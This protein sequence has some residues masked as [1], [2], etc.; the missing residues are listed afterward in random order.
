[1]G[2][3]RGRSIIVA[4]PGRQARIEGCVVARHRPRALQP[5]PQRLPV[6]R[7]HDLHGDQRE[8]EKRAQQLLGV[9]PATTAIE[10]CSE[11][12]AFAVGF[13]N[14]Q[15]HALA[16]RQHAKMVAHR[17]FDERRDVEQLVLLL[18]HAGRADLVRRHRERVGVDIA[19]GIANLVDDQPEVAVGLVTEIDGQRIEGIAEQAGIA[20]QQHPS[21]GEVDAALAYAQRCA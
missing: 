7:R 14:S 12:G 13:Q 4:F 15:L 10:G 18:P 20:E 1:M 19:E 2:G 8:S 11:H 17:H 3:Q 9:E 6:D 16:R 5:E 21:A